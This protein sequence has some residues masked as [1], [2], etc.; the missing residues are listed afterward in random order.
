MI[1]YE[2]NNMF[3]NSGFT[4]SDITLDDINELKKLLIEELSHPTTNVIKSMTV[5]DEI[6]FI[7]N[8][9]QIIKANI[10]VDANYFSKREGIT[11][12]EDGKIVLCGWADDDNKQPFLDAFTKWVEYLKSSH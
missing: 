1:T 3:Y 5:S 10:Y 2:A 6:N 9:K 4:Y 12:N 11:F 7:T 8:T